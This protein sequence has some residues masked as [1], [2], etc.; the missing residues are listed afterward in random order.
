M[1]WGSTCLLLQFLWNFFGRDINS[2]KTIFIIM[3]N[4]LL[5]LTH[6]LCVPENINVFH[7]HFQVMHFKK[8]KKCP[9]IN[10]S[11][12]LSQQY[13]WSGLNTGAPQSLWGS[14]S[15]SLISYL[16]C[17]WHDDVYARKMTFE[18]FY[19]AC[20]STSIPE[21][22]QI[23]RNSSTIVSFLKY[24]KWKVFQKIDD[25]YVPAEL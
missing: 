8:L 13:G 18:K 15:R 25:G 24:L 17:R 2:I 14:I 21:K 3:A 19:K 22:L 9:A 11:N 4:L 7:K 10:F 20:N 5:R 16:S 1:L 6:P 12:K 23:H